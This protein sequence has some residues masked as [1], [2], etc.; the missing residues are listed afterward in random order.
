MKDIIFV[1]SEINPKTGEVLDIGAI[2]NR[3]L[4]LH[5]KTGEKLSVFAEH[6][7]FIAG[8]NLIDHDMK[9]I[10]KYLVQKHRT[11]Y[12]DTLY[13]SPLLF[14][15]RPYHNLV[16]DDKLQSDTLSNPLNDAMKAMDL[17]YD[18]V[19]AFAKMPVDYQD[20]LY[21]LLHEN[22][23]FLGF[24]K[25][26]D[27]QFEGDILPIIK[28]F[29]YDKICHN[30]DVTTLI[31][32]NSLELAYC[33]A[34]LTAD[35]RYALT[36]PW[37]LHRFPLVESVM[38]VLTGTPCGDESCTYCKKQLNVNLKLK[39]IF[40]FDAFRTYDGEPLQEKAADA[41]V[42]NKSLLAIFP[43]GGGK[44]ITFQLPALMAGEATRGLT[45]VL[46][47][48]QS[49]MKDQVDN[50]EKSGITDAVTINGL[51]SP[52]ERSQ[53]I[54]QVMDGTASML[55]LSPESLRSKTI[56]K[57]L[58]SRT[59]ARFVIDE[60]HC[61]SSWGQDF[62]VD[63]L[64]IGDFIKSLQEKKNLRE[65]IPVSCFT[66]T[67]KQKVISDIRDYFK[68]KLDLDL[69]VFATSAART[70]LRYQV[71]YKQND[72]EKYQALRQL[73]ET[74]KCPTIVYV[75]RTKRT[76]SLSEKLTEDGFTAKPFNG[77]MDSTEKIANQEDFINGKV[78][79]IVATSAFGM[80]VDKKDVQLVVH[81]DISDSLEN[82]VQEAGRAGRDQNLQADC[83]VLF[84]DE[85]LDKHFIL[86]NQTK[87][88]I[89]EIQQVWRAIKELSKSRKFMS[90]SALEI[91]RQAGWDDSG[92]NEIET[93]V[94]TAIS[95][96][97][98][99]GYIKRGQNA[100]R[101]FATSILAKNM[102]E[103]SNIIRS[104]V[105]FN[106]KQQQNAIR[107][108]SSL[109]SSKNIAKAGNDKAESRVDY[110]ADL[111]AISKEE[112]IE[113]INLMRLTG[114][115]EDHQDMTAFM[116]KT[117]TQNK[118]ALALHKFA[119][120][121]QFLLSAITSDTTDYNLK[122][123]NEQAQ[124][125]GIKTA[126]VKAIRT[127]LYYWTIRGYIEKTYFTSDKYVKITLVMPLE[128]IE[129]RAK[130]RIALCRFIIDY[131]YEKHKEKDADKKEMVQVGYSMMELQRAFDEQL[132]LEEKIEVDF[133][134]IKDALLYLS[135]VDSMT[136]EGGFLVLY[137]AMQIKRLEMNNKIQYK[138]EDYAKLN[139]FY[140][141]KIQ[142]IHI[143]GEYANMMVRDYN[144]A[145]GF[146]NDYFQLDYKAF[147][148]KY[149]AEERRDEINRNITP[150]KY[151]QLFS[152]LS[153][154]QAEIITDDQSKYIAVIA[155]PGSGKTRVLVH[156]LASLL[157]LEDVKHEQLLML[158][159]SRAAATEFKMRLKDLVGNAAH[160]VEIKTFHSYCFDLL[161]KV[162]NIEKSG[163]IVAEATQ[164]IRSGEVEKTNITKT[165][166]VI[167]EA[168][169]MDEH[170]YQLVQALMAAN[171]DMR[172]IA[173][174]DD[175]QNIF[176]FRGASAKHMK[177]LITHHGAKKVELLS[178]YRSKANIVALANRFA[179]TMK[180]RLKS[181]DIKPVLSENGTVHLTKHKYNNLAVPLVV[182]FMQTYQSG[183]CCV[184]TG[185]NEEAALVAGLLLKNGYRAKLIQSN[186]GFNLYNLLEIRYLLKYIKP[187]M[188]SKIISDDLWEKAKEILQNKYAK[189]TM[190]PTVFTLLDA[191]EQSSKRKYLSDF[192]Q[193]LHESKLE[194]FSYNSN[195]IMVSTIH[196][197][198][199]HEF[200]CVYLLLNN[201]R[202][203]EQMKRAIYVG[204]TRAKS[205]LYVHYN[206][207]NFDVN[208]LDDILSET[209][210][211]LYDEPDEILY[212]LSYREVFLDFF[213]ENRDDVFALHSGATLF[214]NGN[215][216]LAKTP[217][218]NKKIVV[219]SAD[220][221]AKHKALIAKKYFPTQA[222]VRMIVAWQGKEDDCEYPIILPD[223]VYRKVKEKK[224]KGLV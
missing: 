184:L 72:D 10:G 130:K 202:L 76:F 94:R 190:L 180:D 74:R 103:A 123:L 140:K 13:L 85:D 8:H 42:K 116:H 93:R 52:I 7:Q 86:L 166:V 38:N 189:S 112:V 169:D 136:L 152:T 4:T 43:T 25:Y 204:M 222:N 194:D 109:I 19:N 177:H 114:V 119:R 158:T 134:D 28:R 142:Q 33:F 124:E 118:S 62:R 89:S 44:S 211:I 17:F 215:T 187:R 111:L 179:L 216:L 221:H 138:N 149:F 125:S 188:T 133:T 150:Q 101:V 50:L 32:H 214:V 36:P 170:E 198:K 127:I 178:N 208:G 23:Y 20:I 185:T 34:Q 135:K 73:I 18:E 172:V 21:A 157:L 199:G 217:A 144:Q 223:I 66:A 121:E 167:D 83:F 37:V 212:E 27:K 31:Q 210:E 171:D 161:G 186:D 77:K 168:Q 137:N 15:N 29:F 107:I 183:S 120:L 191:F 115:L 63:Y 40:G 122:E 82:Y 1:D 182:Q 58:L 67:A 113:S 3:K 41:A 14:V 100:P 55:Y 213:K 80:G 108:V 24:F 203:D 155:G 110:L 148:A 162:G 200:D 57:I 164:L 48:L 51:L 45:V 69:E 78:Q 99:A 47:P 196:K 147:L 174:G 16:K 224:E 61:F 117:D 175:D 95:A 90:R 56:E 79:I 209:D 129:E 132:S 141:Q 218:G 68:E 81:Y 87:L 197:A 30:A 88:S 2:S 70:N 173:V 12:I 156:K 153:K 54:A 22:K 71:L 49:L 75:S 163:N 64:Y 201:V 205:A 181:A 159:F 195:V 102:E 154:T 84:N 207:M 219:F 59:I 131:L 60:A 26:M 96:L 192:E 106:E 126:T 46:S 146:V 139:A 128:T 193:F 105:Y 206:S 11:H 92:K 97:E 145:L 176:A 98:E 6:A 5:T 104:S 65:K 160:F 143:V 151:M 39:Q 53:A 165:V 91:A 9:Y 35:D 220:Y